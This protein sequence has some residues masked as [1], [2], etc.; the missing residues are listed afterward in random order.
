VTRAYIHG[1]GP[2]LYQ[3]SRFELLVRTPAGLIVEFTCAARVL[4]DKGNSGPKH[5]YYDQ[6]KN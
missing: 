1:A 2:R 6:Y 3:S 4:L 5:S